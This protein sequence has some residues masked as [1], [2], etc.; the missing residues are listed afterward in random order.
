M[1]V[2][3][4]GNGPLPYWNTVPH[5]DL[6]DDIQ[7]VAD[8]IDRTSKQ[9]CTDPDRVYVDGISNGGMLTSLVGCRLADKVA[10]IAPVAGLTFPQ[11]CAPARPMPVLA[12]HGTADQFLT[13]DGHL[14]PGLDPIEFN[15]DSTKAFTD[16][17]LAPIR[18]AA[19]RW[20]TADG[21]TGA[22]Q[23]TPVSAT[24]TQV[25]VDTC[26]GGATVQL[27]VVEGGGHTWPGSQFSQA[28]AAALGPTTFDIDANQVIWAFFQ[29]H[30]MPR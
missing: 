5:A 1:L 14:G 12:I 21:C 16:L 19:Q 2:T 8:I 6:P 24:V 26:P 25:H 23:E 18:D 11:G 10:A 9:L 4:Q 7:F 27:Y 22:A 29:A 30:P 13:F 20:A 17:P 15:A 3:P 28:G